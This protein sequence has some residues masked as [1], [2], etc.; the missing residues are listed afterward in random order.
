MSLD[1]ARLSSLS[2]G[3]D[4]VARRAGELAGELEGGLYAEAAVALFE[5]ERSLAMAGRAVDRARRVVE[6]G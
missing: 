2:A 4:D 6:A 3:V 1:T 5:A